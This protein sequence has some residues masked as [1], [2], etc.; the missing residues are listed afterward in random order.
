MGFTFFYYFAGN[1]KAG[2]FMAL[3]GGLFYLVFRLIGIMTDDQREAKIAAYYEKLRWERPDIEFNKAGKPV[4]TIYYG[5]NRTFADDD[6]EFDW[7]HF[8]RIAV[9]FGVIAICGALGGVW[10]L[11]G[12]AM[13]ALPFAVKPVGDWALGIWDRVFEWMLEKDKAKRLELA[14]N[15]AR[16]ELTPEGD[17]SKLEAAY[18]VYLAYMDFFGYFGS[19]YVMFAP[20]SSWMYGVFAFLLYVARYFSPGPAYKNIV[21][22]IFN[23]LLGAFVI[24]IAH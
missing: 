2:V 5:Y 13:V 20:Y 22:W 17:V 11:F 1:V 3:L 16:A 14:E 8:W 19:L 18:G 9:S 24:F 23:L 4:H 12:A 15:A 6:E 7:F 10:W 21:I